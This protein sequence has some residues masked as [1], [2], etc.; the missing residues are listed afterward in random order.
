MS[1][2]TWYDSNGDGVGDVG[3]ADTNLDG[4]VDATGCD[5][6]FDGRVDTYLVDDN[7]D[8]VV[9]DR[10]VAD[11]D[12]DGVLDT[13]G[14]DVNQDGV[15]DSYSGAGTGGQAVAVPH[16]ESQPS[17]PPQPTLPPIDNSGSFQ[18]TLVQMLERETDPARR[19]LIV[20]AITRQN[21]QVERDIARFWE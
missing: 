5:T 14:W 15:L 20:D 11:L 2:F 12:R 18:E 16:T 6:D 21:R 7:G 3:T 10:V 17:A 13:T 19:A 9:G 1:E 8:G 4:R